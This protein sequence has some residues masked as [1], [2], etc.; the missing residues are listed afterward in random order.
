LQKSI[1]AHEGFSPAVADCGRQG[2]ATSPPST[3]SFA[4]GSKMPKLVGNA[5]RNFSAS[6]PHC[7][8]TLRCWPICKNPPWAPGGEGGIRTHG[9]LM[10][11]TRSPGVPIQ[12]A[13]APLRMLSFVSRLNCARQR[14]PSSLA[15]WK[16]VA[17]GEGFEPPR[18][19]LGP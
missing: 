7:S 11:Y 13:L 10:R 4:I 16:M 18:N 17:E 8:R 3:T 2:T 19:L 6:Q 9:T 1:A 5:E 12:P 15:A 14:L